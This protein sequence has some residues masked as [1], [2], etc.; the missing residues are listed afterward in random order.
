M[1]LPVVRFKL[2]HFSLLII[3]CTIVIG[4]YIRLIPLSTVFGSVPRLEGVCDT[5][6]ML[7]QAE[8]VLHNFPQFTWFYPA[9]GYPDG[10]ETIEMNPLLP[11]LSAI[12]LFATKSISLPE[13]SLI[14]FIPVICGVLLVP[15]LYGSGKEFKGPVAG[16]IAA[17]LIVIVPSVLS[18]TSLGYLDHHCFEILFS[19]AFCYC[20][21]RLI[22]VLT[23][24]EPGVP[25]TATI[26]RRNWIIA[27]LPASFFFTLGIL[28]VITMAAFFGIAIILLTVA[29]C[30]PAFPSFNNKRLLFSY[31]TVFFPSA[32]I[33]VILGV[34]SNS[35]VVSQT[36]NL[37]AFA[38][39]LGLIWLW[40]L[41]KLREKLRDICGG[42][43]L[44]FGVLLITSSMAALSVILTPKIWDLA[45]YFFAYPY[46]LNLE[47]APLPPEGFW[48]MYGISILP[49]SAGIVI[50]LY[51]VFK[52][53]SLQHLFLL[54]W[55]TFFFIASLQHQRH[56]Y[57]LDIPMVILIATGVAWIWRSGWKLSEK[58]VSDDSEKAEPVPGGGAERKKSTVKPSTLILKNSELISRWLGPIL[59]GI[60]FVI[61]IFQFC[62]TSSA[63]ITDDWESGSLDPDFIDAMKWLRSHSP[64][65]GIEPYRIYHP[66]QY[67]NP[68]QA[69]S[70]VTP[71]VYGYAANYWSKQPVSTSGNRE[72]NGAIV[73][74]LYG[75]HNQSYTDSVMQRLNARYI[76]ISADFL[77]DE[78]PMY[79]MR[80]SRI[81]PAR[82]TDDYVGFVSGSGPTGEAA[83]YPEYYP[84]F[85]ETLAIHLYLFDGSYIQGDPDRMKDMMGSDSM[86]VPPGELDALSHFRL[87]YESG[88]MVTPHTGQVG[89]SLRLFDP[90]PDQNRGQETVR[91]SRVKIFEYVNGTEIS[92]T[93]LFQVPVTTNQGRKFVYRQKFING[94]VHSP[95]PEG[96][97]TNTTLSGP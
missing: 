49:A 1:A 32:I 6:F 74:S 87:V 2:I 3:L 35:A 61:I 12:I 56:L 50:C 53:G 23:E 15:V 75:S 46:T 20:F 90:I 70:L 86:M 21:I 33:L 39:F 92:G 66:D 42:M 55:F 82:N 10:L 34:S 69:Y 67:Q 64:D 95:Y 14:S 72:T 93:G 78:F 52:K 22:P 85:Y 80:G 41:E 7:T 4:L 76:V 28:N 40:F 77:N 81:T 5:W 91:V 30:F 43:L 88:T 16:I 44:P 79:V 11:F 68:A 29:Y 57:Y 60:L 62:S 59:A 58:P 24:N 65:P 94:T 36:F 9:I 51:H 13:I 54:L 18:R 19:A 47:W 71:W 26:P 25:D 48:V 97:S 73:E 45:A 27:A 17:A 37:L 96:F 63:W 38:L 89:D 84:A 8:T 83:Y 31:A